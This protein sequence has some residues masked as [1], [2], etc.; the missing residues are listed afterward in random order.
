MKIAIAGASGFVGKKIIQK[1]KHN[2][3]IIGLT[4]GLKSA[5]K[6]IEWRSVDLYSVTSSFEAL[7]DSD[8]AIYLVHSMLPSSRL[9][10]GNFA[11]TDMLLADNFSQACIKHKV[12]HIIY[13]GGL[14]PENSLSS[15]LQSRLE[16][17]SILK[18]TK[19]PCTI[20]RSGMIVGNEGSSYEILKNLVINLPFM[21]LPKWAS[22]LTQVI[23]IDDVVDCIFFS[24]N[25]PS[26]FNKTINLV[27]EEL[28]TY[29]DLILQT[30]NWLNRKILTLNVPINST[31]FS[32]LW[33]TIFGHSKYELVSPLIDSLKC[34]FSNFKTD[35][36]IKPIIKNKTYLGMLKHISPDKTTSGF[37]IK[38]LK[39]VG[40]TVRSIQRL[41]NPQ[42]FNANHIAFLYMKWLPIEMKS[43][44]NVQ[45]KGPIVYFQVKW[46]KINLLILEHIKSHDELDRVKFHIIGGALSKTHDTG[47]LEFR[48]VANKYTLSI[49]HNFI[50]SL[51]WYIYLLTQAII[52]KKVMNDFSH[53][54]K[55][56]DSSLKIKFSV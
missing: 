53:F 40:N 43:L 45:I 22:T 12:K 50:P 11:D 37:Y 36:L 25:N 27:N 1:L 30:A 20:F 14:V 2:F 7:K 26:F 55:E 24:I 16:V 28:I 32:K 33:V 18:S 13:L 9:F 52:H 44:I 47:W 56:E 19:I 35:E 51:P 46:V 41:E 17:E 31:Q 10:Q 23:Y 21:I 3:E 39:P 34:D 42:L 6:N 49:I 4:R 38:F 48:L 5:D 29:K 8:V 15:H 54:I